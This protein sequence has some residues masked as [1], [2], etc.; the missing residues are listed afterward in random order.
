[1]QAISEK[2]RLCMKR[3][4]KPV[5]GF[6]DEHQ[7]VLDSIRLSR[8]ILPISIGI[9]V[10][11]YLLWKQF[12]PEEFAKIRWT[13]HTLFWMLVSIG[14]LVVKHLSY[15]VRLWILSDREFSFLKC[16]ELVVIWEFSSAVSPTSVG[17]S[18]VAFFVL[19]QEKLSTARTATIVLYT[20]VLD[21]FFFVFSALG[22]VLLLGPSVIRP[23]MGQI[24]DIDGWGWTFI[25]SYLAMC[26]YGCVFAYGLLVSP[27]QIKRSLVGITKIGFLKKYRRKMVEL[28][29]DMI[30][31]SKELRQ[32][33]WKYHAGAALATAAAWS[34]RFL[35][36]SALI[37][38]IVGV[39]PIS[40]A[41]IDQL[42]LYAR[43]ESMFII[44]L[45]S[46]TPGGAGFAEFVFGGFL[47]DYVPR[48]IALVVAS[49]WR[50][51]TYYSYLIAGVIVIP[52]WIRNILNER[53]KQ[54]DEADGP[55]ST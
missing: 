32:R 35:L 44:T 27:V 18:A 46:P 28:G 26:T 45:F 54:G 48:G 37:I 51:I 42:K 16:I 8:I 29:N 1:L 19:S 31:A 3:T 22:L 11:L 39:P 2:Q 6:S 30:A 20:I 14:I 13:G 9:V 50:L 47:S 43:L 21:T 55:T 41:F 4:P 34:A 53:K 36:L 23:G 17:G 52:Y 10:V 40:L 24:N 25:G 7:E 49:I 15:S 33:N 5:E 38:A 12:D